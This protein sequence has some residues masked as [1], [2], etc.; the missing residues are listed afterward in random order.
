MDE[1]FEIDF[2]L[3]SYWICDYTLGHGLERDS[4]K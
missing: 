3:T 1:K 4:F 2:T